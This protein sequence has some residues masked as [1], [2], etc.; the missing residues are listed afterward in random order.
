MRSAMRHS[1]PSRL[2]LALLCLLC[3][4]VCLATVSCGEQSSREVLA[5]VNGKPITRADLVR[6]MRE[7]RGPTVLLQMIDEKL[8]DQAAAAQKLTATP[9]QLKNRMD[10]AEASVGSR[11]DLEAKL[12]QRGISLEQF[13]QEL[14]HD[15]YLAQI[16]R[17]ETKTTD[18]DVQAYYKQFAKDFKRGDRV[19]ARMMLFETRENADAVST[20]LGAGGDFEG[21]AKSFSTDPATA[22]NGGNMGT[23]ERKDFNAAITDAAF[24]QKDGQVSKPFKVPD[25]WCIVQTLK[26]VSGGL[27]PLADVKAEIEGRIQ[28]DRADAVRQEWLNKQRTSAKLSVRDKFLSEEVKKAIA[29]KV[30]LRLGQP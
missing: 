6:Q 30:P 15:I 5:T 18:E 24:A 4:G 13:Q 7:S 23:I 12:Q 21:L 26:H 14:V 17:G 29:G 16:I 10:Q 3:V 8:I 2:T 19:Q 27:L 11:K 20:A 28:R 9:E 22:P 1:R 25:G